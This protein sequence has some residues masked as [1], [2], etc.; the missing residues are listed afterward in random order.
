M[1]GLGR[2]LITFCPSSVMQ[3]EAL[4]RARV[5]RLERMEGAVTSRRAAEAAVPVDWQRRAAGV[6][7]AVRANPVIH[8]YALPSTEDLMLCP[9]ACSHAQLEPRMPCMTPCRL[10]SGLLLGNCV[11]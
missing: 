9:L 5:A 2:G 4:L 8:A 3:V 10:G 7:L 11:T 1:C 6:A